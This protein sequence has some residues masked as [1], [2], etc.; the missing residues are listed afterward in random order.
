MVF[1]S[2]E[3]GRLL[4]RSRKKESRKGIMKKYHEKRYHEKKYHEKSITKKQS[5]QGVFPH[6]G[7]SAVIVKI[8]SAER[9]LNKRSC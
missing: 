8:S 5:R 9:V 6:A 4:R 3:A 7:S 2:R 1:I